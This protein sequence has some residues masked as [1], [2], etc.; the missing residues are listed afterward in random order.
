MP[1]LSQDPTSSNYSPEK[2]AAIETLLM[3][4]GEVILLQGLSSKA[5]H[6]MCGANPNPKP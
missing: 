2:R 6:I 5:A 3:A 4:G 1:F